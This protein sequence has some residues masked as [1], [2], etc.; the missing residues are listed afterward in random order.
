VMNSVA[1]SAT[2]ALNVLA[3]LLLLN[4][5]GPG[6]EPTAGELL[7]MLWI[8]GVFLAKPLRQ[9]PWSFVLGLDSLS[10]IYRLE[11]ALASPVS[12]AKVR[13]AE[14]RAAQSI[15]PALEVRGM[16]LE[17]N[18]RE[19][20]KP[21]DLVLRK[22]S[23]TAIVGE[24]GSGK[25]L[26]LQSLVGT[27]GA[28]FR[29]FNVDG[30]STQGP[31]DPSVRAQLA[32]VPQE[33]FTMSA[34]LRENVL[35]TY[36]GPGAASFERDQAVVDSLRVA[37]F[38]PDI[39]RVTDG[40]STEIGERGVNLSGGQRQRIALAIAHYTNRPVILLDDCLS[41]VD[42]D[43]EKRL[44]DQLILGAWGD[45]TRL[46]VT[47]R[48]TILP[49]CDEVI[50][51]ENGAIEMRGTYAELLQHS[52]RFR[53]FVRREEPAQGEGEARV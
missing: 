24:V 32:F 12:Q 25:S 22:G 2:F 40:I 16:H 11:A 3:V 33:G 23:L 5:R 17:I 4:L 26:I 36:L 52:P 21:M 1:G 13:E 43:T 19:L 7:S 44:I 46:L 51:L 39:E 14:A 53:E 27:V 45:R 15:P 30:A 18:G 35:F 28:T 31:Q 10:S 20:L 34:S 37:Q 6:S 48:M 47:H 49:D 41:A 38:D 42:V 29:A 50:F 9:L 8:L